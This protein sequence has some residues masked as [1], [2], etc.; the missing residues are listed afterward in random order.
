M[1]LRPLLDQDRTRFGHLSAAPEPGRGHD[2]GCIVVLGGGVAG[3][4]AADRLCRAGWHVRVIERA[5]SA[6]GTH[7]AR[8]FGPY[9][10]DVGSMFYEQDALLFGLAPEVRSTCPRVM[11]VQRRITPDGSVR[12]Y[13]FDPCELRNRPLA[14]RTRSILDLA[15]SRLTVRRDGTLDAIAR[16]RLGG[17]LFEATGLASYIAR[18]HHVPASEIDEAFFFHRMAFVERSTRLGVLAR[19]VLHALRSGGAPAARSQRPLH[20]RP[21]EGFEPMFEP[22]V[23]R[24]RVAGVEFHF[25][26]ELVSIQR[27]DSGFLVATATDSFAAAGVVSTIPVEILHRAM[28][29]STSGLVSLAMTT[30]FVSARRLDAALGNVL[31]NFHGTGRWKRATIYSRIYPTPAVA[32]EFL[33]V[34]I[35][36]PPGGQHEPQEAFEDFRLHLTRLGLA[37]D[38]ILEGHDR[39]DNC[40][41]LYSPGSA[42]AVGQVLQLIAAS[43]VVLA[44]RQ[45]RFEYLPTSSGVIRRVEEELASSG[46]L[47]AVK[48][49]AA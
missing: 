14:E 12:R 10:F 32:R 17:T 29:G 31:F 5:Q 45:G 22:I 47:E 48:R 34:E 26:E 23:A 39:V 19:M 3:L 8:H 16:Q 21:R 36:I 30:L 18:F 37:E 2:P 49:A 13:P 24:L 42:A 1:N 9:T 6:G 4:A 28:F 41:P 43:G 33:A 11:R 46:L 35:T 20:V 15:W 7:R 38:L 25:G 44:G 27:Q 40:Y